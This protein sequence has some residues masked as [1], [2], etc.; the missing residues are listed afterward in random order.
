MKHSMNMRAENNNVLCAVC[1][2][3]PERDQMVSLRIK[4]AID[5]TKQESLAR[6][7]AYVAVK[8][9]QVGHRTRVPHYHTIPLGALRTRDFRRRKNVLLEQFI[10]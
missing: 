1:A 7:L 3:Q 2:A 10:V 6:H 8:L 4:L 9:L 5:L